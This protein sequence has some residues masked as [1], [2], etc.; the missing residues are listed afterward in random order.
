MPFLCKRIQRHR[1]KGWMVR[2][3]SS[4]ETEPNFWDMP[5]VGIPDPTPLAEPVAAAAVAASVQSCGHPVETPLKVGSRQDPVSSNRAA[6]DILSPRPSLCLSDFCLPIPTWDTP[7]Q[8]YPPV[9][10]PSTFRIPSHLVASTTEKMV[11]GILNDEGMV[12]P[13]APRAAASPPAGKFGASNDL[14]LEE[15]ADL[16][17]FLLDVDLDTEDDR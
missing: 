9:P 10:V 5:A 6:P 2:Q 3:A 8:F 12:W 1:V 4:P 7:R 14:T 15:Q 16:V 17:S 13:A 11:Q